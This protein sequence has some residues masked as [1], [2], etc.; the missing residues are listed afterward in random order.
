EA[1]SAAA[2]EAGSAAAPEAGSAAAPEAG[3][4][5]PDAA[6]E[7]APAP[8]ATDPE[9]KKKADEAKK[10]LE[11]AKKKLEA[12][13]TAAAKDKQKFIDAAKK[14][15]SEEAMKSSAGDL[16]WR[17]A[18]SAMLGDKA[19]TDAVKSLKPGEMTPV[20]TTERGAYLI[21]AED[22]REGDL[23]FDQVKHEIARQ[24]ALDVWSK[25]AARRAALSALDKARAGTGF[26]LDQLYEKRQQAP[27]NPGIDIQQILNNPNIPP[28]E[29]QKILEMLMKS[30]GQ[31][32]SI[33]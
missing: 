32:G 33:E 20:I 24:M 12:V 17:T 29:K 30:Q 18:D 19:L 4:A 16:G 8:A 3:S 22:Q 23:T 15:N 1:G 10:K 7:P 5:A 13:R 11:D 2:P 6:Q 9:A 25:E 31:Q 26:S 28:E 14:L 27:A 21:L